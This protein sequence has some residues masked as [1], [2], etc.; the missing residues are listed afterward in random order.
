M[1]LP[2]TGQAFVEAWNDY[3]Q[4]RIQKRAK[5]TPI[6]A[7]RCLKKLAG[8]GE[9]RATA[10]LEYSIEQGWTGVFEP[11]GARLANGTTLADQIVAS[12]QKFIEAGH[13]EP[14]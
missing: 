7:Q 10:A 4:H 3:L 13:D 6:A 9:A 5:L 8:W 1:E 12:A 14:F 11:Q 2:F